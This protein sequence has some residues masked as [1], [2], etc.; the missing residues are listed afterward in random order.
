MRA[1]SST[2]FVC[3]NTGE[4]VEKWHWKT[5]NRHALLNSTFNK[6]MWHIL[7]VPLSLKLSIRPFAANVVM[8]YGL[9]NY[10]NNDIFT[11]FALQINRRAWVTPHITF[12][13]HTV[14][15]QL[16][17]LGIERTT[18]LTGLPN[19]FIPTFP[20]PRFLLLRYIIV[21]STLNI[22]FIWTSRNS[23]PLWNC[24]Q[25]AYSQL[26]FRRQRSSRDHRLSGWPL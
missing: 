9:K 18:D 26:T 19:F 25:H 13:V 17:V 16:L 20:V 12:L 14:V 22:A 5:R 10:T 4:T 15:I 7:P 2:L 8:L 1:T 11:V 24:A 23:L 21:T 6:N 3:I